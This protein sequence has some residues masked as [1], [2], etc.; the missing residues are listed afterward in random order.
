MLRTRSS[1]VIR[2]THRL[3]K[4]TNSS[5]ISCTTEF[6]MKIP[7][8]IWSLNILQFIYCKTLHSSKHDQLASADSENSSKKVTSYGWKKKKESFLFF[9]HLQYI[10]TMEIHIVAMHSR[11]A[12]RPACSHQLCY[13]C[14]RF[15]LARSLSKLRIVSLDMSTSL[16]SRQW[17]H[18]LCLYFMYSLFQLSLFQQDGSKQKSLVSFLAAA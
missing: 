17:M 2:P 14:V 3:V 18:S 6:C 1:N 15:F 7:N 10:I 4:W 8:L 12:W 5:Q 16:V 13:A 11:R 9:V